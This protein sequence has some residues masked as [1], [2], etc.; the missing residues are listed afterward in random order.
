MNV[1]FMGTPEFAVPTLEKLY[2]SEHKVKL[3]VTQPDKP[4]GRGKKIK[5]SDVKIKA[6][7]LALNVFQPD[8]IKNVRN[9]DVIKSLNP[10]I[11]VVVAYGQ[12][13]SRDI[14]DIPKFGCIN[15]HASLLPELRGAAPLNWAIINGHKKTGVTT[16]NMDA[17]LDTGDILLKKEINIDD[18]ANVGCIHDKLMYEGA[19]L[20][21]KTLEGLEKGNITPKKQDDTLSTYA[22]LLDKNNTR[23]NWK[24]SSEN[25]HNLIR[26]LSPWPAAYFVMEN[27][28]VKVFKSSFKKEKTGFEEGKVI[29]A[30]NDGIYIAA[31][32]GTVVI[33][34]LQ[35]PG[36]NKM[37]VD[38]YLR[39]NGFPAEK[40]N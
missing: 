23:I 7:K 19:E 35:M 37:S 20:L 38:A 16:M 21:L 36:K 32:D 15:V 18:E 6:E 25:I 5:K 17:G 8:K 40:L 10:D 24:D 29:K 22:P 9:V 14:L 11:I 1:I 2:Q 34:E 27:K 12:I 4:F 39:G 33:E 28:R 30:E 31:S 3:V 13:L 26:G